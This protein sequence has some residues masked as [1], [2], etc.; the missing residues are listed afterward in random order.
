MVDEFFGALLLFFFWSHGP[1]F[2]YSEKKVFH[3]LS[4]CVCFAGNLS[5]LCCFGFVG[6]LGN[7]IFTHLEMGTGFFFVLCGIFEVGL[8]ISSIFFLLDILEMGVCVFHS[9]CGPVYL[10]VS[11]FL[12]SCIDH[13]VKFGEFGW[14]PSDELFEFCVQVIIKKHKVQIDIISKFYIVLILFPFSVL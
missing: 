10:Y 7:T 2:A 3:F 11:R 4:L 5:D 14:Y 8:S 13:G 12:S 6:W 9:F 1:V